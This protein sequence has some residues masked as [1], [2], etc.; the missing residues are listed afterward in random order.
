MYYEP[1]ER[2]GLFGITDRELFQANFVV[3]GHFHAGVPEEV[4][5]AYRTVEYLLAS[6]WHYW[7][8]Y[9]E[10][11]NK[12]MRLIE[13]AVKLKAKA[14]GI[15]LS[16]DDKN[17]NSRSVALVH[18]I[19]KICPDPHHVLI[20]QRLNHFRKLR[21]W[22]MHPDSHSFMGGVGGLVKKIKS[23][24][25]LLNLMFLADAELVEMHNRME[26]FQS[27]LL[28]FQ[29]R[30]LVLEGP[31]NKYLIHAIHTFIA[32]RD[33]YFISLE[34]VVLNAWEEMSNHRYLQPL[35]VVIKG[36]TIDRDCISGQAPEGSRVTLSVNKKDENIQTHKTFCEDLAKLD[37]TSR[38]F[39]QSHLTNGCHW[40]IEE[41]LYDWWGPSI[42]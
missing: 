41:R 16:K 14:L 20:K 34:P 9:D 19:D 17:G 24:V 8:L 30:L 33:T 27:S 12:A 22:Q 29:D 7:P 6:A 23:V 40:Q 25:N 28:P 18:L 39:Y 26:T 35:I 36:L 37:K 11:F 1:D 10:G 21:N 42:Q 2:W 4:R 31:E 32:V 13:M 3:K 5:E 38:G 15:V